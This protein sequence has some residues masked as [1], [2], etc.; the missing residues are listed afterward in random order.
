VELSRKADFSVAGGPSSG[1]ID[2]YQVKSIH[3]T[4][5][6]AMTQSLTV[7]LPT[8][9]YTRIKMRAERANRSVEDEMVELLAATVPPPDE[10]PAGRREAEASLELLD[11]QALERA[12]Q[13]RLADELAAEL[14]MLHFRQQRSGLS[15]ADSERCAEL[16]RA[17]ER[18][19]LIRAQA[20]TLLKQRGIDVS[21]MVAGS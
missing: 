3:R 2:Y 17:Y 11:N 20:A 18:S 5:G 16:L 14:E 13:S 12:A 1:E 7:E 10:M 21:G 4:G 15:E 8:G 9:L 19:M 6:Q